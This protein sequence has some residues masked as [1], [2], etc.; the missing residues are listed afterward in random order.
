M[1]ISIV[2]SHRHLP[3]PP[4]NRLWS[5]ETESWL[6]EDIEKWISIE[7]I[8]R[9]WEQWAEQTFVWIGNTT[10]AAA[11]MTCVCLYF[12]FAITV[13]ANGS[14]DCINICWQTKHTFIF[15]FMCSR[16]L[17]S[18]ENLLN[19]VSVTRSSLPSS[20]IFRRVADFGRNRCG[21]WA[22]NEGPEKWRRSSLHQFQTTKTNK[23]LILE[24][25]AVKSN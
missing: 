1:F 17:T 22:P 10:A 19:D 11:S 8:Q 20:S 12:E 21:P 5:V 14:T 15:H 6:T 16:R 3:F 23:K 13:T 25:I 24:S 9:L 4:W 7:W 18:I 2:I